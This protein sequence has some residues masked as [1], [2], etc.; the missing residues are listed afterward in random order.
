[1]TEN[2]NVELP[3]SKLSRRE[4][5]KLA[6]G[7]AA[8][9]AFRKTIEWIKQ[10]EESEGGSY[11]SIEPHIRV[12]FHALRDGEIKP[13]TMIVSGEMN[14]RHMY[15]YEGLKFPPYPEEDY[16]PK[17]KISAL[18]RATKGTSKHIQQHIAQLE[19]AKDQQTEIIV[20]D[21]KHYESVGGDRIN[22]ALNLGNE[23]VFILL[24]ATMGTALLKLFHLTYQI[25]SGT[26]MKDSVKS[27]KFDSR[28]EKLTNFVSSI[29]DKNP[30]IIKFFKGAGSV[31][32]G[33]QLT[34]FLDF[35]D[36]G[37]DVIDGLFDFEQLLIGID[38][39]NLATLLDLVSLRNKSMGLNLHLS[40]LMLDEIDPNSELISRFTKDTEKPE[41]LFFVGT[42]HKESKSDYRKGIRSV[43]KDL[44]NLA[45][46][47]INDYQ[48]QISKLI[49]QPDDLA[50]ALDFWVL[51]SGCFSYPIGSFM[52]SKSFIESSGQQ[53]PYSPRALLWKTL[54]Y[55]MKQEPDNQ[56][57][58]IMA[59]ALVT[60]AEAHQKLVN[61]VIPELEQHLE[62]A[63]AQETVDFN[64][65]QGKHR[66][67]IVSG[68]PHIQEVK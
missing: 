27:E 25:R 21:D 7:G 11:S 37:E 32:A 57:L 44:L 13:N 29:I 5:L 63:R 50:E 66:L 48:S 52:K 65:P 55:R 67:K 38:E 28:V 68:I 23:R 59:E 14:I 45:E 10:A 56:A 34:E 53:I 43:S 12:G 51:S 9:I 6:T 35:R 2:Q 18:H 20:C 46:R 58:P 39:K 36:W 47:T 60:E 64:T 17:S 24:G 40:Q 33:T 54:L 61:P 3:T 62:Q 41:W 4:F 15:L 31:W 42:G 8:A 1:M 49:D 26:W 22:D 16:T 19:K 30:K